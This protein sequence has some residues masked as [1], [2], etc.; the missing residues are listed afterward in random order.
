MIL[1]KNKKSA[2]LSSGFT[3]ME[4][5]III[6]IIGILAAIAVPSFSSI[7]PKL[8]VRA[9]ARATLN[10]IRQARSRAIS[11]GTQYGVHVDAA[12]GQYLLFKDTVNP[13]QMTYHNGDSVVVGP[14]IIDPDVNLVASTFANNTIIFQQTGRASQSGSFTYDKSGGGAQYTIS[15]IGATGRSK[16]Q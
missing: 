14:E 15:V 16:M 3:M 11:E 1:F 9:Q 7:M 12:N 13:A 2:W 6:V 10:Y 4:M 5:M 8:E